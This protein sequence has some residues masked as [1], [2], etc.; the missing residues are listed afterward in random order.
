MTKEAKAAVVAELVDTLQAR[1]AQ[2]AD[3]NDVASVLASFVVFAACRLS[4]VCARPEGDDW[5]LAER[6]VRTVGQGLVSVPVESLVEVM[7][8]RLA[9]DDGGVS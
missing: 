6:I 4:G 1:L 8:A 9:A 3:A 7:R 5:Q 2:E